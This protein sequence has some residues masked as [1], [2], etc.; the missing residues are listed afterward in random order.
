[1]IDPNTRYLLRRRMEVVPRAIR[2]HVPPGRTLEAGAGS[3]WM[4]LAVAS[5]GHDVVA[6]RSFIEKNAKFVVNLDV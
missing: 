2:R 6:R 1:M 3:G 5:M 4:S